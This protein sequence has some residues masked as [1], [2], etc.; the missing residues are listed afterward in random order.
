MHFAR[1]E[2][3]TRLSS[4]RAEVRMNRLL[5]SALLASVFFMSPSAF[6]FQLENSHTFS[7][8]GNVYL[9]EPSHPASHMLVKLR[10]SEGGDR[11]EETTDSG[12]FEFR[13]L[14]PGSYE[15]DRYSSGGFEFRFLQGS[16]RRAAPKIRRN[17][18]GSSTFGF[19]SRAFHSTKGA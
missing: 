15:L 7:I 14:P 5:R 19:H 4:N 10:G 1:R 9:G 18:S 3:Y 13:Q 8:N 11:N 17:Q 2:C 12:E 6:A 16:V